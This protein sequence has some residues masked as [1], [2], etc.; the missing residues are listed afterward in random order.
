MKN[1][2][3]TTTIDGK[4]CTIHATYHGHCET[5]FIEELVSKL[6]DDRTRELATYFLLTKLDPNSIA[7]CP[8]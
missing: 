8:N 5:P 1:I 6:D 4:R 2:I 3:L 7:I